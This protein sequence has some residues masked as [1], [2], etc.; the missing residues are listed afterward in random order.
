MGMLR[1]FLPGHVKSHQFTTGS[2]L[3]GSGQP[4]SDS[5][6]YPS[7]SQM[8]LASRKSFRGVMRSFIRPREFFAEFLGEFI[9]PGCFLRSFKVNF[10]GTFIMIVLQKS[11]AISLSTL[12]MREE[13][14]GDAAMLT[15]GLSAGLGVMVGILVTGGNSG[16]HMNPAVSL[17]IC[18]NK[19]KSVEKIEMFYCQVW[20]YGVGYP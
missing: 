8:S 1:L 13:R 6:L 7:P 19:F 4:S 14:A 12:V 5:H 15:G 16:A 17:G 18:L 9:D 2:Q 20:R 3:T 11:A 10:L